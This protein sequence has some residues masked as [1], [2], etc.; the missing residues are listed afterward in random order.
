[1]TPR[2]IVFLLCCV[3]FGSAAIHFFSIISA[4]GKTAAA[5]SRIVRVAAA[6]GAVGGTINIPIEIVSQGDENAVGFSLTFDAAVLS[7][8]QIT[9]GSGANGATINSNAS[10]AA[11]GRFGVALAFPAN[12]K[13]ASG[14]R[15]MAVVT[16]TVAA[17]ANFGTTNLG[18]G[19]QPVVREVADVTANPLATTFTGGAVTLTKGFEADVTPRPDGDNNGMVT[20]TD[21]TQIGLFVAGIDTPAPGSEFQRA[22]CAPRSGLGDGKISIIDWTQ[23]GR[24]AAALDPVTPAGGPTMASTSLATA[25]ERWMASGG[26][27]WLVQGDDLAA[28]QP[29]TIRA[30]L[31]PTANNRQTATIPIEIDAQ[32]IENALGFSL[33][34]NASHW[35]LLSVKTGRDAD[36]AVLHINSNEAGQGRVGIA[37]AMPVGRAIARGERELVV[38]EFAAIANRKGLPLVFNF[39][40]FPVQRELAD[41]EANPVQSN[42]S[43]DGFNLETIPALL[44][45]EPEMEMQHLALWRINFE[46]NWKAKS[47]EEFLLR[48][49]DILPLIDSSGNQTPAKLLMT[50][51]GIDLF[52]SAPITE[53][54]ATAV[55]NDFNGNNVYLLIEV[56]RPRR[57]D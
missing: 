37:L 52:A 42:F 17:S 11:Q 5:Q 1:M 45:T 49:G 53:G 35:R 12:Q 30:Q 38:C 33:V 25:R 15:Q 43:A 50:R 47:N 2:K 24:Y 21:W 41:V 40:D 51:A 57:I 48:E 18:F 19:D 23:A 4:S 6:S 20:I 36:D 3:V 29:T 13:F 27:R 34:F 7:N 28:R 56:S 26:E 14:V 8:P 9:L 44:I 39:A 54:I 31:K 32:G 46:K 55:F 10:Q 22:D 16:F